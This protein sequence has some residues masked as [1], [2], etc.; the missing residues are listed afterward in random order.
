MFITFTSVT[1]RWTSQASLGT[2]LSNYK[3][4]S[5]QSSSDHVSISIG[6]FPNAE[7]SELSIARTTLPLILYSDRYK[8]FLWQLIWFSVL[9]TILNKDYY[10][11][12]HVFSEISECFCDIWILL[13]TII[14]FTYFLI[15]K[16]VYTLK[17]CNITI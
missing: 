12:F 15:S 11:D 17:R 7:L 3:L 4:K 6:W 2:S 8:N 16:F 13:H 10:N 1:L 5:I 14:V 9:L